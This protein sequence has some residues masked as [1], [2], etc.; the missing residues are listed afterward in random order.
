MLLLVLE[1]ATLS[2]L[3]WARELK[4]KVKAKNIQLS[5]SRLAWA[6]ELKLLHLMRVI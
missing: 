5:A 3:A 6:R 4:F 1:S 2:R